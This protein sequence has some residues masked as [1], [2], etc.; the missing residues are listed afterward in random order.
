[1]INKK[2]IYLAVFFICLISI[3]AVNATEDINDE[4][5]GRNL[6]E[7]LRDDISNDNGNELN[8]EKT[9]AITLDSGNEET[10]NDG[11]GTFTDLKGLIDSSEDT[12]NLSR[13]YTYS[14][15]DNMEEG[16]V[17]NRALT[18]EG[19]GFTIN[20]ANASGI[21]K[22]YMGDV[23][24]KNLNFINGHSNYYGGAIDG[25]ATA[26]NCT[27]ANNTANFGGAI[28]Q[29]TAI[30]CTFI[31]NSATSFGGGIFEG[32]SINCT[33]INNSASRGGGVYSST[34]LDSSFI[35]NT[36]EAFGG[37]AAEST[38]K[39]AVLQITMRVM[40]EQLCMVM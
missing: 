10:L 36:A 37:A 13:N 24:I 9:D 19:N 16:I 34:A 3:S 31:Q 22:I 11:E 6:E 15:S 14:E 27:F 20:G 26:I 21:F 32:E 23:V 8:L 4:G 30:N 1:M 2:L 39:I 35:N 33:F 40:V 5:I 12:L 17:I 18:I 29:A 38:V 25:P 7:S 28:R